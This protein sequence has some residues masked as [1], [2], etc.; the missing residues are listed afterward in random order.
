MNVLLAEHYTYLSITSP[1]VQLIAYPMGVGWAKYFPDWRFRLFGSEHSLNPGPFNKKEHTIISMMTAAGSMTSYA[2]SILISQEIYYGQK[3]GWGFQILLILSTQ[4]MGFGVAGVLRR[5]LVWPA[6]MVW[7]A[8]LITCSIMDGLHNHSGSDPSSTNG[9]KMGRYKFFLI[10]AGAT[11]LWEWVPNAIAP[12]VAYLGQFPT[13]IAPHNVAVN[14]VFGG[15]TSLG[16]M[17]GTL[18]WSSV[19]GYFQSPLQYPSFTMYNFLAGGLLILV[20]GFGLAFGGP[21]WMKHLPLSA[22]ANFDHFGLKYNTSRILNPDITLNEQ[23]YHAYS[24]LFI[25]PVFALSYGLGFAALMATVVHV[26]LF[27]GKDIYRRLK[28]VNY[29]E[30]DVHLKLMRKYKEA[31]EW[32]FAALFLGSFAVGL[33]ASLVW[34]T[35]LTW[36]GF[37]ICIILGAGLVLPVGKGHSTHCTGHI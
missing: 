3:W 6:A 11:F 8:T 13:W 23:A 1:V 30:P 28:D 25:G 21:S 29:E 9:W 17:P 33:A 14:Q 19:S 27:Y 20:A 4:A 24:P 37:I 18:D 5:F 2:I 35:K 10:V 26:G 16:F 36:W 15:H 7:P 12:F 34:D 32:W 22:N 31:P